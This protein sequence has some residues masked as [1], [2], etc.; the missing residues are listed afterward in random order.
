MKSNI[1]KE[2]RR[3]Y[4]QLCVSLQDRCKE[5]YPSL[6][7][8]SAAAVT[9][10]LYF[11]CTSICVNCACSAHAAWTRSTG[12]ENKPNFHYIVHSRAQNIQWKPGR[13]IFKK[14]KKNT[15][16][17]FN[18]YKKHCVCRSCNYASTTPL[19]QIDPP[20]VSFFFICF[21][22]AL[23]W[24]HLVERCLSRFSRVSILR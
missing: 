7:F 24:R 11:F 20:K 19:N 16:Q 23:N 5:K 18:I 22:S 21:S 1:N 14:K 15:F 9:P 6:M 4:R 10:S 8:F 13:L 17:I 12:Y 3:Q 2:N